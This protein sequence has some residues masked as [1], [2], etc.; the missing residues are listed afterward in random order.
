MAARLLHAR[1]DQGA[2]VAKDLR[3]AVAQRAQQLGRSFDVGHQERHRAAGQ[4][5]HIRRRPPGLRLQPLVAELAVE[6]PDRHDAVPLR[7]REE[8]LPSLLARG[9][10][11]ERGLIETCERVPDMRRIVDR[12]A[13]PALRVDVGERAGR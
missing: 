8:P 6:E 4:A 11:L 5:R 7:G 10:V 3:V 2:H 9:I 12:Q 13:P 1:P